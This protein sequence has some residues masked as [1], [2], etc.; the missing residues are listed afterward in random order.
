[1][2][3]VDIVKISREQGK[4]IYLN[5]NVLGDPD[6]VRDIYLTLENNYNTVKELEY[7]RESLRKKVK[8]DSFNYGLALKGIKTIIDKNIKENYMR[9]FC[10]S[11]RIDSLLSNDD[12]IYLYIYFLEFIL[13]DIEEL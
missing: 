2:K 4:E 10:S 7:Y 6:A 8:K 5:E 3:L 13:E 12:R 1:M 11:T 9:L